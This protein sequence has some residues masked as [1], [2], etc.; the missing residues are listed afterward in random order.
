MNERLAWLYT[1]A[2]ALLRVLSGFLSVVPRVIRIFFWRTTNLS[3]ELPIVIIH[4]HG[5]SERRTGGMGSLIRLTCSCIYTTRSLRGCII[6]CMRD[7]RK[8]NLR[9]EEED[10]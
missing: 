4:T 10:G 8:E 9:G 3:M 7:E 5:T 2:L 6:D 1:L